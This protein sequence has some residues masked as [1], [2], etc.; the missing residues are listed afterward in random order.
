[1]WG[2]RWA[3]GGSVGAAWGHAGMRATYQ[4]KKLMLSSFLF[5][6]EKSI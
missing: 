3:V 2:K 1:M 4:A 6:G 5:T